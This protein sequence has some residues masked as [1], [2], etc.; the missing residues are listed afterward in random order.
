MC[1]A[2]HVICS[3]DNVEPGYEVME[4]IGLTRRETLKDVVR[5]V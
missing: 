3:R 1:V 5:P 2:E 4:N